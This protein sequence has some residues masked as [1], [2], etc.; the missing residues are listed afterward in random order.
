M[1]PISRSLLGRDRVISRRPY[2]EVDVEVARTAEFP[3]SDLEGNGHLIIAM[4]VLMK[5]LPAVGWQLNVVGRD[6]LEKP[7]CKQQ[8]AGNRREEHGQG[9]RGCCVSRGEDS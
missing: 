5:A 7:S 8:R 1:S 9:R 4:E 6:R 2:P 3:V